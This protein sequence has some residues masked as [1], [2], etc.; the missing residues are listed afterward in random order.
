MLS[1]EGTRK[2]QR[3]DISTFLPVHQ[4]LTNN[5]TRLG[6]GIHYCNWLTCK[7]E[8]GCI[9]VL[10]GGRKK[11]V[12]RLRYRVGCWQKFCYWQLL[13]AIVNGELWESFKLYRR[14]DIKLGFKSSRA[15]QP[16]GLEK[17]KGSNL[18]E[19]TSQVIQSEE[20]KTFGQVE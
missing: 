18:A 1:K 4:G 16:F 11:D 5:C 13:M 19:R 20:F 8:K 14:W 15:E 7:V 9:P 10:M 6:P 17:V 3:R 12:N 2:N